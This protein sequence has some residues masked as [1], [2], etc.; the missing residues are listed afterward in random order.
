MGE[1]ASGDA[2]TVGRLLTW[3]RQ[4]LGERGVE[5]SRL[6]TELLLAHAL[7]CAKIELYT[8]YE[9]VPSESEMTTFRALVRQA[10][11][12]TPIAYLLG[13][14]EFFSLEFEV[15][16]AVLV[17][18]PETETLVQAVIDHCR[19]GRLEQ[20]TVLDVG[21]G[22]GCIA[23]AL[24][25]YVPDARVVATDISPEA[26]EVAARNV[27]RHQVDE[28][29]RLVE[30]DWLTLPHEVLPEGGFD[31]IVSNPPY[32]S[33]AELDSL[34]RTVRDHEPHGALVADEEGLAAY[35]RLAEGVFALL[36]ADGV[37]VVEL[38]NG[39]GAAVAELF[40][41]SGQ[42]AHQATRQDQAR[43]DRVL[44]FSTV[45]SAETGAGSDSTDQTWK[46]TG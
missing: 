26:L 9:S 7:G 23:V 10:G 5:E 15:S 46:A 30:A 31:V 41:A 21:T 14:K 22:S 32:V 39:Q 25:K 13:M 4:W 42:L 29:V 18:R 6:A 28:Q 35:R 16:P 12:H 3:T 38:G 34:S 20:P 45:G 27:S 2:W 44:T 19:D 43:I 40:T 37:V 36:A 24:A 1:L 17:P 11:E 8:R 33:A